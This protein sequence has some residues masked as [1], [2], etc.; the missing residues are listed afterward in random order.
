MTYPDQSQYLQSISSAEENFDTLQYLVPVL[1]NRGEPYMDSGNLSVVF[2][3]TDGEKEYAVKCFTR[4]CSGRAEAYKKITQ[5]LALLE[6]DYI[7]DM[8]YLENEVFVDVSNSSGD[9]MYPV[10]KMEWV[11]GMP[12]DKY[13]NSV[14]SNQLELKRLADRFDDMARW[15]LLQPIAHGDLK[16]DNILVRGDGSLAL[17]D[18]DGMYVPAMW[19]EETRELG[20]P[21]YSHP[22]RKS[23]PFDS[24]ADDYAIVVI[25][26]I[27]RVVSLHPQSYVEVE[28]EMSGGRESFLR[29]IAKM[30]I[31][32]DARICSLLA[33][34]HVVD[35]YGLIDSNVAVML[36]SIGVGVE[37]HKL[38]MSGE[39]LPPPP[40]PIPEGGKTSKNEINGHSYVDLGLSVKWATMNVGASSP[41]QYGSY[42]AWGETSPKSSYD[43][44]NSKTYDNSSYNHD[45]GGDSFTDAARANWGGSWRLPTAEEFRELIDN[46]NWTWTTL[47]GKAGYKVVSKKNGN[48]IF[49]PAA[50]VREG[51]SLDYA[52][53]NGKYWSSTPCE[54]DSYGAG[55]LVFASGGL[56]VRGFDRD[57]G[58]TVRPVCPVCDAR[59]DT[60]NEE[61]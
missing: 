23:L 21:P 12:L 61:K 5:S 24:H 52:G 22:L 16:P 47:N 29:S 35:T 4:D 10:L 28:A 50:G 33:A 36:L 25:S 37:A 44:D 7:V 19:G 18:Y 41:E 38:L 40:E 3:M 56:G 54:G 53:K 27:L 2:K 48:S 43:K 32:G 45:I 13:V 57:H 58:Y 46:C 60:E 8:Q 42:F 6:S 17:V 30:D 34:Y 59:T 11:D 1:N 15:L 20:T 39:A 49:L 26:L 9:G 31:L 51:T 55:G 14:L